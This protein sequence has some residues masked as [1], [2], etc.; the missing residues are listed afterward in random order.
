MSLSTL[1]VS[2]WNAC[3]EGRLEEVKALCQRPDLDV[4]WA[5]PAHWRSPFYRA[6][7]HDR[8]AVVEY[9]LRDPRVNV[10]Q[11][12]NQQGTPLNI[13]CQDGF[14]EV[15]KLLLRDPRTD[16]NVADVYGATPLWISCQNGLLEVVKL[17]IVFRPDTLN[18]WTVTVPGTALWNNTTALDIATEKGHGQ[19]AGLLKDF[20]AGPHLVVNSLKKE[21]R[22]RGSVARLEGFPPT[23]FLLCILG[24]TSPLV[25]RSHSW[26]APCAGGVSFR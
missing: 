13:A 25:S 6:C 8:V 2:L 9:L 23:P 16:V 22:L 20:V 17:L 5:D 11:A 4:N 24:L 26:G 15:V 14:V 21:F 19:I 7:S 10:N 12:Q 1:E 18:M 3:T